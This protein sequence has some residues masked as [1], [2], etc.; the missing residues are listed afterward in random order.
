MEVHELSSSEYPEFYQTY[1]NNI[2]KEASLGMLFRSNIE[3]LK[4]ITSTI[5]PDKLS[6]RYAQEKWS[7]AEVLQHLIDVE[8]IF[9]Y[10]ALCISRG[11]QT[12]LPGFDHDDYVVQSEARNRSLDSLQ[13]EAEIVRSSG[14]VLYNSFSE[15]MLQ[16]KGI[17][18]G[19]PASV[20]AIGFIIVG[21]TQH[22]I[23]ILQKKYL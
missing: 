1:I 14:I 7:I 23:K 10:R 6:F 17:L 8:R 9:H 19:G 12:S 18:N 16:R 20:R 2:P 15:A 22:H 3:D 5:S 11:D 21:H 4:E 13:E